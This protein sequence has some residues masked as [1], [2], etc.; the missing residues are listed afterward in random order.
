MNLKQIALSLSLATAAHAAETS[1][2]FGEAGR[3]G[4]FNT[5]VTVYKEA[6]DAQPKCPRC[7]NIRVIHDGTVPGMVGG[8]SQINKVVVNTDAACQKVSKPEERQGSN[9][10]SLFRMIGSPTISSNALMV[11]LEQCRT[12]ST[13]TLEFYGK[14]CMNPTVPEC[15]TEVLAD[16][17]DVDMDKVWGMDAIARNPL[18]NRKE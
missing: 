12:S 1:Q 7:M 2:G 17:V 11:N 8:L 14:K 18:P 3:S 4:Q 10:Q 13:I 15:D 9:L 6:T 16:S 5:L